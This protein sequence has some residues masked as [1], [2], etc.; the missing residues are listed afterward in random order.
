MKTLHTLAALLLT[1]AALTACNKPEAPAKTDADVMRATADGQAKVSE[2]AAEAVTE[3][4]DN[5]ADA[6][7]EGKPMSE[8]D[9]KAD[10]DNL[11]EVD[12][13]VADARY[14]IAKEQC[15]ALTGDQKDGCLKNAKT[16]HEA[17]LGQ[18]KA[19]QKAAKAA[20]TDAPK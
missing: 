18:A 5:A 13:T 9:L 1:G 2:A 17:E 10:V 12:T 7:E 6:R 4:V 11:H 20:I 14:K 3:H 19:D 15:D 16:L 8:S